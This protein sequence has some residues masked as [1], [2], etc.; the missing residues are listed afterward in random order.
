M[1]GLACWGWRGRRN[2]LNLH[3][4]GYAR[5]CSCGGG[6]SLLNYAASVM[7]IH[8]LLR[9]LLQGVRG[10]G[11]PE[12]PCKYKIKAGDWWDAVGVRI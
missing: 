10:V 2:M 7:Q 5:C 6:A 3:Q 11:Q 4:V 12:P 8:C 1:E 9:L